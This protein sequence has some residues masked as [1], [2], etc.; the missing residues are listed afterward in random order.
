MR[1]FVRTV[2]LGLGLDPDDTLSR[3]LGEPPAEREAHTVG[4]SPRGSVLLLLGVAS[5]LAL[6]LGVVQVVLREDAAPVRPSES[7]E[8]VW[9]RDPVRALADAHAASL[10]RAPG[11]DPVDTTAR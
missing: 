3:M 9:R 10:R 8:A 2:A 5:L 7:A 1:G 4:A 6:A 11:A